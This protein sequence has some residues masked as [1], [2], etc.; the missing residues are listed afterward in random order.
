MKKNIWA[1]L[2]LLCFVSNASA[3]DFGVGAKAGINGL[4]IDLS[5]GLTKNVNLRL[6]GAAID[7]EGENETVTV[8]DPGFEGDIEADL[9]FDYSAT[10]AFID[11]HILGGGF[12]VTAGMYKNNGSADLTGTL[13]TS[14]EVDDQPLEPADLVNASVGGSVSLGDSYQPYI[15]I[16][17]GRGA[18]DDAGLSFMV[19]VG[20]AIVE[21]DVSL[22]AAVSPTSPNYPGAGGQDLLDQTLRDLESDAE[23]D[24]EDLEF[25]PVLSAGVNFRF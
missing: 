16:G 18:G 22:D 14:I 7:I 17:W 12:R 21:P 8:G 13:L 19:D 2:G 20:V 4:G 5:V 10:A 11:W 1:V 25:W 9:D 15:G 24:L 23:S 3:L 6:S